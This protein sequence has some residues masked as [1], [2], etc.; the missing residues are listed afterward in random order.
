MKNIH[1]IPTEKPSRLY[2]E[3]G[4]GDLCLANGLLPQTKRS[5]NQHLYI[6]SDEEIKKGD[7]CIN[8]NSSYEH[9]ELCR[10]DNQIELERYAQKIGND[11]KKIILT[12]DQDLIKDGVQEIDD[13]FLEWFA[14]K[15]NRESVETQKWFDGV[16]F[17]EYKIIIPQEDI[18]FF[19]ITVNAF[20]K[21]MNLNLEYIEEPK[22]DS[23]F[24]NAKLALRNYLLANNEKVTKDLQEMREK[25][26]ADRDETVEEAAETWVFETN[27]HKWSNND[28]TAGDNYGSFK[29]GATWQ[30][31]RGYTESEVQELLIKSVDVFG[32][33]TLS[34]KETDKKVVEWFNR[35]KKK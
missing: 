21:S 33:G 3:F 8:L 9:K 17:L 5:N 14:K 16:D 15:P 30:A 1:I 26:G 32:D 4:D 19:Q 25:S 13:T 11:C 12:T 28:D 27:G 18:N 2:L 34:E 24:E 20:E 31:E 35:Y 7:W 10:I 22:Q 29:A 23:T 6:T